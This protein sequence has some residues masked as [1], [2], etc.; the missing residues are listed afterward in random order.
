M[1]SRATV[2]LYLTQRRFSLAPGAF[3]QHICA[4]FHGLKLP[5]AGLLIPAVMALFLAVQAYC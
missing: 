5:L 2:N 1:A 3:R 4:S